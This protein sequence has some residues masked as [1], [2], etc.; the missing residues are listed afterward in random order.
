MCHK[1]SR[2]DAQPRPAYPGFYHWPP[3]SLAPGLPGVIVKCAPDPGKHE[4][5]WPANRHGRPPHVRGK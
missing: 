1:S 2:S 5:A 4:S 3:S